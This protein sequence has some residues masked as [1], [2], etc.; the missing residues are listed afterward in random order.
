MDQPS[1]EPIRRAL[2]HLAEGRALTEAE[3]TAAF[4]SV[5]SGAASPVQLGALLLG[6]RARGETVD[7]L[8]GAARALRS[9]MRRVAIEGVEAMVDTCGTGGGFTRTLNIST[10]AAIVAAGA[11]VRV[12][13]HGNRSFTSRSGSADVLE[14]LGVG[15]DLPVE[16]VERVLRVA[17]VAFLFAPTYHPAMRHAAPVRREL[18]VATVMN[19]VGPLANPAGVTRQVVGVSE[20]RHGMLMAGAMQRLGAVH[21]MVVHAAL[22]LDEIAPVGTT[23]VWEV[24]DN[25]VREWVLDPAAHGLAAPDLRG[26]EGGEP[27]E[28]AAAIEALLRAPSAAPVALRAAVL[29]NAGAAVTVSGQVTNL[30][31]GIAAAQEALDSGAAAARLELLREMAPIRTS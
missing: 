28:N 2:G 24:K 4:E 14:A 30:E 3:A 20:A 16:E 15:V 25:T 9:A 6:L 31:Q 29:L 27:A 1:D 22:G 19:L 13:K 12:A 7:E 17:G 5:M 18:A 10:A 26:T 23:T 21:G 8:A 11:G